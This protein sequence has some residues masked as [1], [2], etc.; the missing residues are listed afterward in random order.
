MTDER[1]TRHQVMA[2]AQLAKG[3]KHIQGSIT[4]TLMMDAK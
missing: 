2:K 4:K 3:Q 1:L